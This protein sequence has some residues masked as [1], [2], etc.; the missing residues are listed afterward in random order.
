MKDLRNL[1]LNELLS[2]RQF[3]IF[4]SNVTN[5]DGKYVRQASST[6]VEVDKE[7]WAR[8]ISYETPWGQV[9]PRGFFFEDEDFDKTLEEL[10]AGRFDKGEE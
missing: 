9:N 1:S 6:L 7:I 5:I 3:L 8:V 10:S 2:A 4:Y